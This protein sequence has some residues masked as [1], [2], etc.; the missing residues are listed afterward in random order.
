MSKLPQ[1]VVIQ[2]PVSTG[3]KIAFGFLLFY[4]VFF[5]AL[6]VVFGILGLSVLSFLR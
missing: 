6:W 4:A 5:L 2:K 3:F 1:E